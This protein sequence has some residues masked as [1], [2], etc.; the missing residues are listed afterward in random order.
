[1][2]TPGEALRIA[3]NYW[4]TAPVDVFAIAKELELGPVFADDL[5]EHVSGLIRKRS[6]GVWEIVV[7]KKH[8]KVRQRF[9]V[10]H[11]IGHFIYHRERLEAGAGTS[12]TLAF[13]IDDRIYPNAHIGPTQEVQANIFAANLLIPDHVL[14]VAQE[15]MGITDPDELANHFEVSRAAMRIKLG[16]P[17]Q[18]PN[19]F[20]QKVAAG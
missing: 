1:M 11:E 14:R 4:G 16:L 5:P 10:A 9:T 7:N 2:K 17:M 19:L 18:Q 6:D 15:M 13:R 12:D 8:P 20:P 3:K